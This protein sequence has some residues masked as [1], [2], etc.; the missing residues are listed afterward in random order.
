MTDAASIT[1]SPAQ[2]LLLAKARRRRAEAEGDPKSRFPGTP[3]SDGPRFP[4]I[5]VEPNS[6]DAFPIVKPAPSGGFP[7][8]QPS[9][10]APAGEP[11]WLDQLFGAG[12]Y[13]LETGAIMADS[14][15]RGASNIAGLPVDLV[16]AS[17]MVLRLFGIDAQPM[18]PKPVGGSEWMNEATKGFGLVPQ[19]PTPEDPLQTI[20]GRISEE[21]GATAVPG[22]GILGA[23]AKTT[24]P[25]VREAGGMSRHLLEPAL[26]DPAKFIGK[27]AAAATAAG[28]GAGIANSMIDRDTTGGQIADLL[29]ALGGVGVAGIGGAVGKSLGDVLAATTSNPKY[30]S[31]V[32]REN[33]A[34]TIIS[35]S[36]TL[37]RQIGPARPNAPVDTQALVE[38]LQRPS[39]AEANVPGFKASTADRAGDFGLASLEDARSKGPNAGR[40]RAVAENNTNAVDS[41]LDTYRP[42]E[43][44]GAFSDALAGRRDSQLMG[45]QDEHQQL[46]DVLN[47][48]LGPLQVNTTP[49][50]RGNAIRADLMGARDAARARTGAAYDAADISGTMVDPTQLADVIDGATAGLT[51][52]ER[53]LI[54]ETLINRVRALGEGTLDGAGNAVAPDPVDLREATTL[55]SEIKRLQR[56]ALA[57][58]R[59]EKGGRNAN[60]VL[61]QISDALDGFI[62]ASVTPEQRTALDRARSA[63]FDEA[64]RFTRAG[65]PVAAAVEQYEGGYHRMRDER[66]APLFASSDQNLARLL[67][68]ADT[69]AVRQSI[70][71]ELLSRL[72][73]DS[74]ASIQSF[75]QAQGA[76]LQRF[77]GLEDELF[78]AV[79]ARA[80]ETGAAAHVEALRGLFG[81]PDGRVP[82]RNAI[83][84][85]LQYDDTQAD[86]AMLGVLNAKSPA[87]T[88]D[89][90]L[91]F[92]GDE[93]AAVEGARAAFWRVMEKK[94]RSSNAA[95][96]TTTGTDPWLPKKWRTFLEQPNV[97]A[98]MDRLYRDQPE[99]LANIRQIAEALRGVNTGRKAGA[100]I[101]PSGSA[102]SLRNGAVTLAEAQ[103][104]FIDV[105]R[106][107]LN[108]L[109]A[110]TYLAGKIANRLVSK[111]SERAYQMLLDQA[112]LEPEIAA[113][114]LRANNPANR[115]AL[116]RKAKGWLGNQASHLIDLLDGGDGDDQTGPIE[117]TATGGL[118][119]EAR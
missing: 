85:Y 77:P 41:A 48:V 108:P 29:G 101:N 104:K 115:A 59:A 44:P 91:S 37:G 95:M 76:K 70:R 5:P 65:D 90:L 2:L 26:V 17:P 66:V 80:D 50:I 97:A 18:S 27:E 63:K 36:D 32:V 39:V 54:P 35:N 92:V 23:A 6:F 8:G 87:G 106:G 57:D 79:A 43:Q 42:T 10:A 25:A 49:A 34:D 117:I 55:L 53:G 86:R 24:L 103:A 14:A 11:S 62:S 99:H 13:A 21:I 83:A 109:Y 45:A 84:R 67:A 7:P 113:E 28:T 60:R 69:P 61:G 98:V 52:A 72:K 73:T 15:R 110:V 82:G 33:A 112:L 1:M 20:L 64:E 88:A 46:L 89:E 118:Q 96:E 116:A 105:Q 114:L 100:A 93:P 30:A 78:R 56:A 40:F 58:P 16:N 81:T 51:A 3:V 47:R 38:L 31:Q 19:A 12:Q 111:Q 4:G 107:R 74:A 119:K 94:S 102:Q 22:A 71:E 75:I 9:A 68:E